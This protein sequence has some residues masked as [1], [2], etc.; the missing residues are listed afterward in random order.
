MAHRPDQHVHED[1]HT[2]DRGGLAEHMR[3]LEVEEGNV[4]LSPCVG[5]P[6]LAHYSASR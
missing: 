3:P 2:L 4:C 5:C 1:A 6:P